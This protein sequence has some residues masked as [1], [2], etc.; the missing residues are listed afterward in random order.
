MI[1]LVERCCVQIDNAPLTGE[2]EPQIRTP[3]YTNEN[4]LETRNLAFF[5]TTAVEGLFVGLLH[6]LCSYYIYYVSACMCVACMLPVYFSGFLFWGVMDKLYL[7][8]ALR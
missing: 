1:D 2:T 8:Y 6:L 7:Y 3:E 5:C 4:P